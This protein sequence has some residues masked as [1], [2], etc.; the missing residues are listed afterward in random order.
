MFHLYRPLA[1]AALCLLASCSSTPR[2]SESVYHGP[3]A[4]VV[5]GEASAPSNVPSA[6]KRAIDA[7][8]Y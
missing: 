5:N 4:V 3:R 7:D 1:V 2:D 8:R 6:V